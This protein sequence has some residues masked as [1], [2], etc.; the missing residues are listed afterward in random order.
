MRWLL[1]EESCPLD[2]AVLKASDLGDCLLAKSLISQ[3]KVRC[4]NSIV[5]PEFLR[6]PSEY[7]EALERQGEGGGGISEDM[8]KIRPLS[9]AGENDVQSL[10]ENPALMKR[11]KVHDGPSETNAEAGPGC[12]W[13]GELEKLEV[14]RR[15][16]G[17]E[18][19]TCVHGC[20][21]RLCRKVLLEH[22]PSCLWAF[23]ACER[24]NEQIRMCNMP[25][26]MEELCKMREVRCTSASCGWS[27]FSQDL[28]KHLEESC[29]A[30]EVECAMC[31]T[32][33]LRSDLPR[34]L[35]Q[36]IYDHM[37]K[38]IVQVAGLKNSNKTLQDRVTVL[39]KEKGELARQNSE[40][41]QKL[42]Y[43][44]KPR[45]V[46]L[47]VLDSPEGRWRVFSFRVPDADRTH[48]GSYIGF[49]DVNCAECGRSAVQIG[50]VVERLR[51][52]EAQ[53]DKL[54]RW[55]GIEFEKGHTPVVRGKLWIK[56]Q[57]FRGAD[58]NRH[59]VLTHN[60]NTDNIGLDFDN[61]K[62]MLVN[63]KWGFI[64][65]RSVLLTDMAYANSV[66][67]F[68]SLEVKYFIM[69]VPL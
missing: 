44:M 13:T 23:R 19:V 4:S 17:Y 67:P 54:G 66:G 58:Q 52:H 1:Q 50:F 34:H 55:I 11:R 26:H 51:P 39:E 15:E 63:D 10:V 43:L 22:Q 48:Y 62:G 37:Q 35:E 20:G 57:V 12:E 38:V 49:S 6:Q 21:A 65:G 24:C 14:H 28:P 16:C 47:P 30:M 29:I 41:R 45:V 60:Y 42:K 2:R 33:M 64:W 18:V 59:V 9:S 3:L 31:N 8:H 32:K 5:S 68:G 27:G 46:E 56:F 69:F 53:Q 7:R 36:S 40:F 61:S 25:Q